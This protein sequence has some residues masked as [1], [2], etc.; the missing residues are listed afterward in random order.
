MLYQRVNSIV[1]LTILVITKPLAG[2]SF[3]S[4]R[5]YIN[6]S[7][8]EKSYIF[9]LW[10]NPMAVKAKQMPFN[11]PLELDEIGQFLPDFC[12][13][14]KAG[15]GISPQ[16]GRWNLKA[17]FT[18]FNRK[19]CKCTS[20]AQSEYTYKIFDITSGW[21]CCW[22]DRFAFTPY[23][24]IRAFWHDTTTTCYNNYEEVDI[25]RTRYNNDCTAACNKYEAVGIVGGM[26]FNYDFSDKVYFNGFF[27]GST[28]G[29]NNCSIYTYTIGTC[30][31]E[32]ERSKRTE[33]EKK[34][35]CIHDLEGGIS[36]NYDGCFREIEYR[37]G[38]GYEV[39][40]W[41]ESTRCQLDCSLFVQ[42]I[43]VHLGFQY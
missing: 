7:D 35:L 8:C 34:F 25:V 40:Q 6:D 33:K 15:T 28:I 13:G 12:F 41:N 24:G 32:R 3:F 30:E 31:A 2:V 16:W 1:L 22:C 26:Q 11:L 21:T 37:I 20:I 18:Y 10:F 38:I 17:D 14:L 19:N 29:G 42:A 4:D 27:G 9:A 36:V 23:G 39:M 5:C 43:V